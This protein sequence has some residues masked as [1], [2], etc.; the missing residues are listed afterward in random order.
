MLL[1]FH[2]QM[3]ERV[4][5][6]GAGNVGAAL[7]EALLKTGFEVKYGTRDPGSEKIKALLKASSCTSVSN[8]N[9][10]S[11]FDDRAYARLRCKLPEHLRAS[12]ESAAGAV[13]ASVAACL[14]GDCRGQQQ[15]E[16]KRTPKLRSQQR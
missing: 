14:Y 13:I 4:A 11:P 7:G 6:I 5:I 1:V 2:V 3:A 15:S 10:S 8:V 9:M 16:L 12:S